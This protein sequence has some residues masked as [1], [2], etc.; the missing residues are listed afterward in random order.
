VQDIALLLAS[1]GMFIA[2]ISMFIAGPIA[3]IT[4]IVELI[5]GIK[6][7]KRYRRQ[8]I[9]ESRLKLSG[10]TTEGQIISHRVDE[11]NMYL[12]YYLGY[13]YEYQE[14]KNQNEQ[15]VSLKDFNSCREGS[16]VTVRYLP[17]DPQIAML[18]DISISYSIKALRANAIVFFF[19]AALF[20]SFIFF[21]TIIVIVGLLFFPVK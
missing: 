7:K 1:V 21:Y 5:A 19:L 9:L 11:S 4:G 15:V 12:K 8:V 16:T 13:S 10:S 2:R 3:F 6:W 20:L 18:E 17:D 14:N